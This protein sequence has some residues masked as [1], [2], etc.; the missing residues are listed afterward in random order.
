MTLNLTNTA[1]TYNDGTKALL[2]TNL[3]VSTGEIV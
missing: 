1:K 3:K 2:S